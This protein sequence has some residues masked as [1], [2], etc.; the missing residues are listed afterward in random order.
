M[1]ASGLLNNELVS[2]SKSGLIAYV[3]NESGYAN[4]CVTLLETINGTNWRLRPSKKYAIQ[5]YMLDTSST[6]N[7]SNTANGNA[8]GTTQRSINHLSSIYWNNT[9]NH[10]GDQLALFDDVGNLTVLSAGQTVEGA[11]TFDK[12][13]VLFQ[14]N[15]YKIYSQSAPLQE[16]TSGIKATRA[17]AKR[18]THA[19]IVEFHWVGTPTPLF[20]L[21]R[22]RKDPSTSAFKSQVQQFQPL[23]LTHPTSIKCACLGLRRGGQLDFWYQFSNSKDYKKISLNLNSC[24]ESRNKQFDWI[25]CGKVAQMEEDQ[26]SIVGAYSRLSKKL[27]F[28]KLSVDWNISSQNAVADPKLHL[29]HIIEFSPDFLSDKGEPVELKGFELLSAT[30]NKGSGPELLLCYDVMGVSRS[31]VKRFK[32]TQFTPSSELCA[33]FGVFNTEDQALPLCQYSFEKEHEYSFDCTI[34]AIDYIFSE[35]IVIFRLKDGHSSTY[36][37]RTW[38]NEEELSREPKQDIISSAFSNGIRIPATLPTTAFEWSRISPSLGGILSK[39]SSK[40]SLRFDPIEAPVTDVAEN[41]LYVASTFAYA[42]VCANHRQTSGEDLSIAI[43]THLLKIAQVS[44]SRAEKFLKTVICTVYQLFGLTPDATKELKDKLIMSRPIQRAMLLQSELACSFTNNNIYNM[45]RTALTLR[46]ILFAFNG[47]SRNIQVLIHHS[48]TM[49]FQQPNGKLFQF[50][51][52]KQDLIYSLIP[53]AKWFVKLVTFLTQ[54]MIVLINSPNDKENTL[55]LGIFSSKMTRQLLLSVLSEI[56]KVIHLVTKFP[57]TS[58]PVLN[59]SSIFLRKVLG[60]SPVN[61]EKFETFLADVNNKFTSL[62]ESPIVGSSTKDSYLIIEGDIPPEV[63]QLKEFLLSYSN[64]AVLSHI[65]PAEVYFSDTRG[66]RIFSSEMFP[67]PY[68]K[69]LQPLEKGIVVSSDVISSNIPSRSLCVVETDDISKEPLG[70]GNYRLKRCCRCGAVSRA[71]YPVTSEDTIVPTS[72]STKRW[73]SLYVKVCICSGLLYELEED[74][75][76]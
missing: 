58:F 36:D 76:H 30:S 45:S 23:G 52:S 70:S 8:S 66:L 22:A 41:D 6:G 35:N 16:S 17:L 19:T 5:P 72:V 27:I 11:S 34:S 42:F 63:S 31:I 59:E 21:L 56:K 40:D 62:G 69:L 43:K 53:G 4:L 12:L 60:D 51:F 24:Q 61:F 50:A 47:V 75:H 1:I 37:R 71:G 26:A 28:Y 68:F 7:G 38:K 9:H 48:A 25:Q 73:T 44:E 32:L 64:T 29:Q 20:A 57:E 49:N 10:A 33:V 67:S 74:T 3:D 2:W 39:A 46:N 13:F 18:D 15:G 14:D 65:K 55:V 54:Q